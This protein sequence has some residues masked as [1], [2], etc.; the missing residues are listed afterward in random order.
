MLGILLSVMISYFQLILIKIQ[1]QYP[2]YPDL[3]PQG[4]FNS[5]FYLTVL[6]SGL[7]QQILTMHQTL[8]LKL[9]II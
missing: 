3:I 4:P 2:I 9:L 7:A 8:S 5:K 6:I 1:P